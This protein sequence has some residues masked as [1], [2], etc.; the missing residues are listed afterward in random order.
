MLEIERILDN[1]P[2]RPPPI[3]TLALRWQSACPP[4]SISAGNP[5]AAESPKEDE[6][7]IGEEQK[8]SSKLGFC[9]IQWQH[10]ILDNNK[11]FSSSNNKQILLTSSSSKHR[12]A[13]EKTSSKDNIRYIKVSTSSNDLHAI[14]GGGAVSPPNT[15]RLDSNSNL[16]T[17]IENCGSNGRH[18]DRIKSI[19]SA[20]ETKIRRNSSLMNFKSLDISLKSI[21]STIKGG[22]SEKKIAEPAVVSA[23]ANDSVNTSTASVRKVPPFLKIEPVTDSDSQQLL[24]YPQSPGGSQHRRSLDTNSSTFLS[25]AQYQDFSQSRVSSPFLCVS[26]QNIRRS[27][28]SDIIGNNKN[29]GGSRSAQESRRPSTSDILRKARERKGSEGRLGRS[30]SQGGLARG[31]IRNRRTS[32]AY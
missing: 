31:G 21:Y 12:L 29:R 2:I 19:D 8:D 3:S 16:D 28:T 6:L 9:E 10:G 5:G 32:M 25:T 13:N 15:N 20:T 14:C 1:K 22:K 18:I 4:G 23:T 17:I 27:S 26:A 11:F 30:I 7:S 24:T